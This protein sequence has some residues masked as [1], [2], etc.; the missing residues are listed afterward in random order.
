MSRM[1]KQLCVLS[2]S[3]LASS[4]SLLSSDCSETSMSSGS[5]KDARKCCQNWSQNK[6][7]TVSA[8]SKNENEP[9]SK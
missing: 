1:V 3:S 6:K 8:T 2:K 9:I 7:T 5:P 4:I